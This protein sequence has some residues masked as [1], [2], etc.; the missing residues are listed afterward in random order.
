MGNHLLPMQAN[1]DLKR[2][3]MWEDRTKGGQG[4]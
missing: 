4:D 1:H 2:H 3:E